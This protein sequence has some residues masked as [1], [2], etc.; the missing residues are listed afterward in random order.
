MKKILLCGLVAGIIFSSCLKSG[1]G[2][3][4]CEFNACAEVAPASEIQAVQSYLTSKGLTATQHCSGLFYKID[5]A[6]TGKTPEPCSGVS[7]TYKGQLTDGTVFDEKATPITFALNSL[8]TSWRIGLP[9]IKEGGHIYL[10][11]PPKLGYGST[12]N[13]AIPANSI[14]VFELTLSAVL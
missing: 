8:I 2:T 1:N 6:G 12:P 14:L 3:I 9:L 11:V 4:S 13:G 10:Y 5:I 7:V